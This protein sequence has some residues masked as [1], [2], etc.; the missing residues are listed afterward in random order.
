MTDELTVVMPHFGSAKELEPLLR[1]FTSM[2]KSKVVVVDNNPEPTVK[3]QV[4]A[5]KF[6]YLHCD[7]PG[8]YN[9]RNLAIKNIT[10]RYIYFIDSDC[11]INTDHYENLLKVIKEEPD[12]VS[13]EV[14]ILAQGRR[15][16]AFYYDKVF[17]FQNDLNKHRNQAIT[18]TLLVRKKLFEQLGTFD[19]NLKSG[20]DIKW[21]KTA[22]NSGFNLKFDNRLDVFHPA[23]EKLSEIII[24]QRRVFGGEIL[25][26]N[27]SGVVFLKRLLPPIK[28]WRRIFRAKFVPVHYKVLLLAFSWLLNFILVFELLRLKLGFGAERR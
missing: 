14:E 22:T 20:A 3:Q 28:K 11:I 9:A 2:P 26:A 24:K 18:A 10:S 8:S 15:G 25:S 6:D 17:S 12:L 13:G 5:A 4:Y 23:R 19:G 7:I 16:L 27:Y 21:T 1:M